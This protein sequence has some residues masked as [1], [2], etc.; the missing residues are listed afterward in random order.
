L[1]LA[2]EAEYEMVLLFLERGTKIKVKDA[3]VSVGPILFFGHL[4]RSQNQTPLHRACQIN[5]I[6]IA[7]ILLTREA[8]EDGD[9]FAP[10]LVSH[11]PTSRTDLK[12]EWQHSS[13][14]RMSAGACRGRLVV[15]LFRNDF[16]ELNEPGKKSPSSLS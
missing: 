3:M 1:H 6:E 14:S 15:T 13:P 5:D 4:I 11:A 16:G 2:C 9:L 8:E 10:D 12:S 7:S